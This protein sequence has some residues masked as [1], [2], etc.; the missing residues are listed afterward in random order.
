MKKQLLTISLLLICITLYSQGKEKKHSVGFSTGPTFPRE[1]G[2]YID[3]DEYSVWPDTKLSL[4][5]NIFYEY[6]SSSNLKVGCHI[7]YEN[8]K[9][10][11]TY[12]FEEEIKARRLV[13]GFHWIG[14]VPKHF[15]HLDLGGYLNFGSARSDEWDTNLNGIEFGILA[16]PAI[17]FDRFGIALHAKPGF[18]Y[19]F[20]DDSPEDI[21]FFSQRVMLKFS[22]NL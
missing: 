4:V 8:T 5:Y 7:E 3:Y 19:F 20:S 16:G 11:I 14:Q 22:Y 10:D 9:S 1:N 6:T 21:L 13:F 17:D 15:I 18:S 12:P 2:M